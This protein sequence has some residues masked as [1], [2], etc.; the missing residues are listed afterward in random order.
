MINCWNKSIKMSFKSELTC[1]LRGIARWP[2]LGLCRGIPSKQS[3]KGKHCL[4]RK[5]ENDNIV[6]RQQNDTILKIIYSSA[7]SPTYK[8]VL[9]IGLPIQSS[10]E[11]TPP[12]GCQSV[13]HKKLAHWWKCDWIPFILENWGNGTSVLV[14]WWILNMCVFELVKMWGWW[15]PVLSAKEEAPIVETP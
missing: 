11:S 5:K 12:G 9:F 8:T 3:S 1:W 10:L 13:C 4:E 6:K 14:D 7:W 2:L 15:L